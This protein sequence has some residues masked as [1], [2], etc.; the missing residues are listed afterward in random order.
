[1]T[2][3]EVIDRLCDKVS[4]SMTDAAHI[5]ERFS[6]RHIDVPTMCEWRRLKRFPTT[7]EGR[8][9]RNDLIKWVL[10]RYEQA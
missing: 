10:N 8:I 3:N 1:M 9:T 5:V 2:P 7:I 6:G 4:F